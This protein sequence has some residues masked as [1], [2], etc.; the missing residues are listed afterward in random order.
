MWV[1]PARARCPERSIALEERAERHAFGGVV[2]ETD[3]PRVGQQR[4]EELPGQRRRAPRPPVGSRT[5]GARRRSCSRRQTAVLGRARVRASTATRRARARRRGASAGTCRWDR[6]TMSSPRPCSRRPARIAVRSWRLW[7]T[8]DSAASSEIV[9]TRL[10]IARRPS[11]SGVSA[12][13]SGSSSQLELRGDRLV[14]LLDVRDAERHLGRDAGRRI[15]LPQGALL[16]DATEGGVHVG[17][18]RAG[19]Q[20]LLGQC[21]ES[22]AARRRHRGRVLPR[23]RSDDEVGE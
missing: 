15:T 5:R 7:R 1:P 21:L 14:R 17:H 18:V 2:D 13:P 11:R 19:A 6:S 4:G 10:G 12:I 3:L 20:V 22:T 9:R 23:A 16:L 8:S